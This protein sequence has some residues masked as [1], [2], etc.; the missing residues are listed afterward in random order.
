MKQMRE[1][2]LFFTSHIQ[3]I[4]YKFFHIFSKTLKLIEYECFPFKAAW[5]NKST[6]GTKEEIIVQIFILV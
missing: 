1:W 2:I 5:I 3:I 6:N 4:P